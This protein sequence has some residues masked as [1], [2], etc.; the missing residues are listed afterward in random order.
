MKKRIKKS[1]AVIL[2]AVM[3]FGVLTAMP[4]VVSA[5]E[6]G[7]SVGASSGKTGDCTYT[8]DDDGTLT[9]SGSGAMKNYDYDSTLPWRKNIT[10]VI[11]ND[12]VTSIGSDAF[13]E[14][15]RLT[16][17][18]IPDSVT[19]IGNYAFYGCKGLT[20]VT[21]GNNVT[22]IGNYAFELCT[23]LTSLTI[24]NNVASIGN[25]AFQYCSKLTSV[26]IPDNVTWIGYAAFEGCSK[27]TS[28]TIPCSVTYIG[29]GAFSSCK[30]LTAVHITDLAAWC[31]IRFVTV[32]SNPLFSAHN[33]YLNNELVTNLNIPNSV[34]SICNYAFDGCTGLTNVTIPSSVTSIG[35][36]AFSGCTGL[37]SVTIPDSV[38]S[39]GYSV[40]CNCSKL[41]SVTIPD[42]ITN[43]GASAFEGCSKLTSVTIPDS[44]TSIEGS[45]FKGCSKL[46]SV[47]IPGNVTSIGTFAFSNCT[48][49]TSVT[50]PDSVTSIGTCAFQ[51]CVNLT[52]VTIGNNVTSIG[53]DAFWECSRLTSVTIP[54]SVTSINGRTFYG[55]TRLTSVT[56]PDSVT[57]IGIRA[58]YGCSSLADVYYSGSE[59][60]WNNISIGEYNDCL[61]Y[62]NIHFYIIDTDGDGLPDEWEMNGLDYD[63]NGTIDVNLPLMGA[64]PNV[65]DIFVEVDWMVRPKQNFLWFETQ[66]SRNLAPS[67]SAMRLVYNAFRSHGINLHIDAG[68]NST[69]FVTGRQW[70]SLSGGNEVSYQKMF[71]INTSWESAVNSNF[72]NNR[73]G[74]FKHCLFLDQFDGT[75]SGIANDIPGQYFIVANQDWVFNGG[76]TSVAG[77]FMHELGHTLGLCHGGCDHEHYKPNYLSIMNYA[78]QTTGLVGTGAVNYSDYKLQDLDEAHI[79]ENLGIDPSGLTDGT[80]LGTTL[81]YRTK[82][83][84]EV[85]PISRTAIDFNNN[86]TLESDISIDL[87][88]KGNKQDPPIAKLRGH[89]DWGGIIFN[90]GNIGKQG[91]YS[92]GIDYSSNNMG[93]DE[94]TLEESLSTSTLAKDNTGYIELLP[95]TLIAGLDDQYLEFEIGNLSANDSSYS[96]NIVCDN[97]FDSYSESVELPGSKDK[98]ETKH[99][100]VPITKAVSNGKYSILCSISSGVNISYF[101]F[102]IEAAIV[103]RQDISDMKQQIRDTIDLDDNNTDRI[104]ELLS[105]YEREG[106]LGDVN[107]DGYVNINDVTAIQRHLVELETLDENGFAVAD[108]NGDGELDIA[109]ATLIQ[110][111]LAEYDVKLG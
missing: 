88:P 20:R 77:T 82:N 8:L 106:I 69:D 43:I 71:D 51:N 55:C 62:A 61:I 95:S 26:T 103:S 10:S 75:T 37:A 68:P 100:I 13:W 86:N 87:N 42:N 58:F 23:N 49:L 11:I 52:S 105:T 94:K 89:Q 57:S 24:G 54:D 53:S 47:T 59:S 70:G 21:V 74:V 98:I 45:A 32:S 9:I 96:V 56:I 90:G 16:S 64:D 48:G 85:S 5:A 33:L 27:L 25:Y 109:D 73:Y 66:K 28:V 1:L 83:Q 38:T 101:N 99:I 92:S 6:T 79:N 50:I 72:S 46:T 107:G 60:D 67:A 91:V 102:S 18:T 15:S 76:D 39:I 36:F 78:F 7:Q 84:R 110:M 4:F 63:G 44:V 2:A 111:Y 35:N 34:T 29:D 108:T 41:T 97:L 12:G 3:V 65:P 81:F 40:F 104:T 22:S 17:V 80:G 30:E 93:L 19:S 14:C 31:R